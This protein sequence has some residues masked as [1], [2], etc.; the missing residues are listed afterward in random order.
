MAENAIGALAIRISADIG[1]L[2]DGFNRADKEVSKFSTALDKKLLQPL[3]KV[4]GAAAAASGGLFLFAKSA[5]DTVDQ[6][7]KLAQKV[8]VTVEQMSAL[9]YAA[10]LSDVSIEGLGAGLRNLSKFMVENRIEGVGVEEQLLR[11]ADEFSRTA[12][13]EYKTAAAMKYFG[14]AGAD[15]IPL[16]NEGRAGIE[17]LRKEA[18]RLGLIFSTE[19]A[20]AAAEF[21]DNMK[22]L[23]GT[24]TSLKV[25]IAG[26]LVSAINEAGKAFLN[27]QKNGEDFFSSLLE[28]YRTLVTGNDAHKAN[29]ELVKATDDLAKAWE[30]LDRARRGDLPARPGKSMADDVKDAEAAVKAA[31]EKIRLLQKRKEILAPEEKKKEEDKK[32]ANV[33]VP[34]D[35]AAA[36][37]A[38]DLLSKQLQE[39]SE[40]E[41]K[42]ASET[43]Q[44]VSDARAQA[45]EKEQIIRQLWGE[46]FLEDAELYSLEE[47][48]RLKA[49]EDER[50]RIIFESID[51]E[52]AA[53]EEKLRTEAEIQDQMKKREEEMRAT[54]L[55]QA[56]TFFGVMA[57]LM[58]TNSK[59]MFEIGKQA[60]IAETIINTYKAAMGAYS[61]LASIPFV[62]PALGAA[63]AAAA[64]ATG[65]A[66]VNAIRSQSFQGGGSAAVPV[67]ASS[68]QTGLPEG[69][70]GGDVG[71]SGGG[72]TSVIHLHGEKFGRAQLR[73]LLEE[74]HEEGRD[75][76]RIIL[77][78]SS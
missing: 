15:L 30:R 60:A 29:V 66:Q 74:L 72:Q 43:A 68:A 6:I 77:A 73:A 50:L 3:A 5:A 13:N 17:E 47:L 19:A 55:G 35:A 54:R 57:G 70:P 25:Q 51:Q 33:A 16:L 21:N 2:I 22:R 39:A 59:K 62:G 53:Y 58:N 11:I 40:E 64:V 56:K 32:K 49:H 26:P 4:V 23:E 41:V 69:T 42:V 9:K 38:R 20:K 10:E 12:D 7:G 31:E 34:E 67:V 37:R 63:A 1:D 24:V 36:Q 52:T 28:G 71:S 46:A 45:L 8:G 65:M 76:G 44:L 14:K 18:E 61:A 27:A 75:G 78:G 48:K